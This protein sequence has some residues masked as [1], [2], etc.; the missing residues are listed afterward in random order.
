[1]TASLYF[2]S[3]CYNTNAG[4]PGATHKVAFNPLLV[5]L[6]SAMDI[7]T[8]LYQVDTDD[9]PSALKM[10]KNSLDR[11]VSD[12]PTEGLSEIDQ[13]TQS[14]HLLMT[15]IFKAA[16]LYQDHYGACRE[17]E[18]RPID[19]CNK[20]YHRD[21]QNRIIGFEIE[22][23]ANEVLTDVDRMQITIY[24]VSSTLSFTPG[25]TNYS[26]FPLFIYAYYMCKLADS[27]IDDSSR[28]ATVMSYVSI[29]PYFGIK[30]LHMS[31]FYARSTPNVILHWSKQKATSHLL[32]SHDPKFRFNNICKALHSELH[33]DKQQLASL[34]TFGPTKVVYDE[35][36]YDMMDADYIIQLTQSPAFTAFTTTIKAMGRSHKERIAAAFSD[37]NVSDNMQF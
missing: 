19:F 35:Q 20:R 13:A 36:E 29:I 4:K 14:I 17:D 8:K 24:E 25:R 18:Y 26:I 15:E 6:Q 7:A 32:S 2:P 21:E 31:E 9:V 23:G 28:T 22:E 5:D 34:F 16:S 37:K 3:F 33:I 1:M 30:T 11:D 10:I 12:I 27:I